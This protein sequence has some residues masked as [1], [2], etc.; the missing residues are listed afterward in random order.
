M[1]YEITRSFSLFLSEFS[2][3]KRRRKRIKE[4]R[5]ILGNKEM[6]DAASSKPTLGLAQPPPQGYPLPPPP[7]I[8]PP[9]YPPP[10]MSLFPAGTGYGAAATPPFRR[11][12]SAAQASA[13]APLL[14]PLGRAG[15]NI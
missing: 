11:R 15:L 1:S 12:I 4:K 5:G 2:E 7:P 10:R 14:T 13:A 8:P 6:T 9:L 3:R